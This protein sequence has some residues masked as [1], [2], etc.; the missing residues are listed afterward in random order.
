[1]G[2][3][4][5]AEPDPSRTSTQVQ[6][7]GCLCI[8]YVTCLY[9]NWYVLDCSLQIYGVV[10]DHRRV[11]REREETDLERKER[12]DKTVEKIEDL[13]DV[14]DRTLTSQILD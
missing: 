1:M 9:P 2:R 10:N 8:M 6:L 5:G 13:L 4:A 12:S 3:A 7:K 14:L 11:G